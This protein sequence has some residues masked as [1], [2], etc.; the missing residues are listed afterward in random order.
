[1]NVELFKDAIA[2]IAG[3][4]DERLSLGEWQC[5][6]MLGFKVVRKPK[7]I[8]CHTIACAG[9]WLALHPTMR[10]HGLRPSP[11][12]GA[13]ILKDGGLYQDPFEALATLFDISE[14]E[15]T[16]LFT[17][18]DWDGSERT[19]RQVWLKRAYKLLAKYEAKRERQQTS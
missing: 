19:D 1:M 10:E 17:Y 8:K 9:G 7:K 15:A 16:K 4:P 6:D 11:V 3:I 5:D 14:K 2:I 13:P 18:R 12:D